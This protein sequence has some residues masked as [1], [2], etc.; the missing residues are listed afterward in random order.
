MGLERPSKIWPCCSFLTTVLTFG[1]EKYLEDDYPVSAFKK[2][3]KEIEGG[4]FKD[5]IKIILFP[6]TS[7]VIRWFQFKILNAKVQKFIIIVHWPVTLCDSLWHY[8][9][10]IFSCSY[11]KIGFIFFS[12]VS[13][14]KSSTCHAHSKDTEKEEN[15]LFLA[16]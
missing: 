16:F 4:K 15:L 2:W 6:T 3:E 13:F 8:D 10:W 7:L 9:L 12:I 1:N 11:R 14:C 5:F